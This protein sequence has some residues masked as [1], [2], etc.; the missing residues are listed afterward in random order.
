MEGK[1]ESEEY[2]GTMSML[3]FPRGLLPT[4]RW[5]KGKK[6]TIKKLEDKIHLEIR[7]TIQD[8]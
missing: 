7:S 1:R 4:P 3:S 5:K 6:T 8:R 2:R